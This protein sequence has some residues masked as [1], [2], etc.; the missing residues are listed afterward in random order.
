MFEG[1]LTVNGF[2]KA[3]AMMGMRLGY[4][5]VEPAK[6]AKATTTIQPQLTLCARSFSQAAGLAALTQVSDTK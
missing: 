6:L 3:Y 1:I 5:M 2:D 4:I